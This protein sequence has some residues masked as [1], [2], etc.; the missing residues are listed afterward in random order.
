MLSGGECSQKKM[1]VKTPST[2]ST[3]T[4]EGLDI[5][6]LVKQ[7][8]VGLAQRHHSYAKRHFG[9][10]KMPFAVRSEAMSV[11][12]ASHPLKTT[13]PTVITMDLRVV[14]LR[15]MIYYTSRC[16]I[17]AVILVWVGPITTTTWI[18]RSWRHCRSDT[19][20]RP[21]DSLLFCQSWWQRTHFCWPLNA[22]YKND[23]YFGKSTCLNI[24]K[25][26]KGEQRKSGIESWFG[27]SGNEEENK[28]AERGRR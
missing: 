15:V 4:Q 1:A 12:S 25:V 26:T 6:K 27:L 17:Y 22:Y 2:G 13:A 18:P 8:K 10:F 28:F 16:G 23:V 21:T 19:R 9:H 5:A 11:I 24:V 20:T 7:L 14:Y 3:I